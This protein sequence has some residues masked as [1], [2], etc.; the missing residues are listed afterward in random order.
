MARIKYS[1]LDKLSDKELEEKEKELELSLLKGI[2]KETGK[3][4]IREIRRGLAKIQTIKRKREE[5]KN[6]A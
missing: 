1:E 3:S 2:N 6:K 5:L 4:N